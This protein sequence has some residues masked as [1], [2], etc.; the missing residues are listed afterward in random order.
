M[1]TL[2]LLGPGVWIGGQGGTGVGDRAAG[3]GSDSGAGITGDR[4]GVVASG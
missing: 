4:E 2:T 1:P 3:N